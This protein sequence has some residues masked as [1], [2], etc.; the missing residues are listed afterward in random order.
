MGIEGEMIYQKIKEFI[1]FWNKSYTDIQRE[2]W[3]KPYQEIASRHFHPEW[4]DW[5]IQ[6]SMYDLLTNIIYNIDDV[7][8][9]T[10]A[11]SYEQ[12][13]N[14]DIEVQLKDAMIDVLKH[15]NLIKK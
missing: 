14:K 5:N 11:Q 12:G 13:W 6:T 7:Y 4:I 2:E 15:K 10:I 3:N 9:K 1:E 8:L